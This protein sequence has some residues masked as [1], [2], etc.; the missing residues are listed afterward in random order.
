[1]CRD[2]ASGRVYAL[3]SLLKSLVVSGDK[4]AQVLS[5]R[6]ALEVAKHSCIISLV[7]TYEDAQHLYL[8]LELALGGELFQLMS[9]VGAF[10]EAHARFYAGSLTLAL[11]HLHGCGYMY[12]DVKPENLLLTREGRLKLCDLGLAKRADVGWTL[13]GTPEY[14][15][16]EVRPQARLSSRVNARSE[17]VL[18]G[19]F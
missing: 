5:E 15:A 2:G 7:A 13:V 19:C 18:C 11:G 8:L 10:D 17:G 1:M 6:R 16:P 3:K 12:R 14:T 9:S 4:V